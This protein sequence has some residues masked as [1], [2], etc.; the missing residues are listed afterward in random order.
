MVFWDNDGSN[1]EADAGYS[2][3]VKQHPPSNPN[4]LALLAHRRG[5]AAHA[6]SFF[7]SLLASPHWL[8]NAA[9][10]IRLLNAAEGIRG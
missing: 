5:E 1:N 2:R 7:R 4:R 9:E 6:R 3:V 8:L 10:G